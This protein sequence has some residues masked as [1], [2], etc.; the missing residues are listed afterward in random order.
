MCATLTVP[1]SLALLFDKLINYFD[2][3]EKQYKHVRTVILINTKKSLSK[4]L[5]IN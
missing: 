2:F 1:Y 4:Q 3:I 5:E